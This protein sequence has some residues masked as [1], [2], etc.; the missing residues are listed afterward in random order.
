ME[1]HL[2]K[3]FCPGLVRQDF[4][5]VRTT[6]RAQMHRRPVHVLYGLWHGVHV[7]TPT[8]VK[9]DMTASE[10]QALVTVFL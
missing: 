10:N 6:N 4:R 9:T 5:S 1:R 7:R 3:E 2:W 8:G